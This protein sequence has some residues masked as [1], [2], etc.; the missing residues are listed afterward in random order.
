MTEAERIWRE[1]SD[2]DLLDAAAELDQFTE[3]GQA[4]VRAELKRRGLEDPLEQA[5]DEAGAP[6]AEPPL[7]CLRCRA[8]LRY[9]DPSSDRAPRW[10]WAGVREPLQDAG[11]IVHVYACPSCGH[12]ELFMDPP[13]EPEEEEEEQAP[14]TER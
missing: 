9:I 11:G 5:G 8:E 4:I 13:P 1:K 6:A 7:E 2:E 10:H 14:P 3:E 12:V